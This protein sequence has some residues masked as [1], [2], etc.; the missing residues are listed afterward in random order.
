[1]E[2][3]TNQQLIKKGTETKRKRNLRNILVFTNMSKTEIQNY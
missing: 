1:M 3:K 2:K